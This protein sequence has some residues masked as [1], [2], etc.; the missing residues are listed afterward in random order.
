MN[1]ESARDKVERLRW[2]LSEAI[3][4][5]REEAK[6]ERLARLRKRKEITNALNG[7]F[8]LIQYDKDGA[9]YCIKRWRN[10][11]YAL[12]KWNGKRFSKFRATRFEELN[13]LFGEKDWPK[14]MLE[15]GDESIPLV[16]RRSI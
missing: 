10:A 9:I 15:E 14:V 4:E 16:G 13:N 1:T 2:E 7:T 8:N 12:G 11:N 3:K 5:R 6:M